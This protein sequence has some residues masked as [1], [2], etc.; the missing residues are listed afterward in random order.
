M[1][2][3]DALLCYLHH[4]CLFI[5]DV[6]DFFVLFAYFISCFY[7]KWPS[8]YLHLPGFVCDSGEE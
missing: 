7:I 4:V 2:E 5:R 8:L 3:N 1:G 6:P